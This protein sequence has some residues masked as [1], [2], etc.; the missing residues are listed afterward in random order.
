MTSATMLPGIRIQSFVINQEVF[1]LI[2]ILR[3]SRT[4]SRSRTLAMRLLYATGSRNGI[5]DVNQARES[6]DS[7][8][9]LL[10]VKFVHQMKKM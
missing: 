2:L 6:A 8:I 9:S 4:C 10:P 7:L 1:D 5:L 3:R